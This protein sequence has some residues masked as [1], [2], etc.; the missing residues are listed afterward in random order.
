MSNLMAHPRFWER[1]AILV[2]TENQVGVDAYPN[3]TA[4]W[5]EARNVTFQPFDMETV[6]RNVGQP[7]FGNGAKLAN[8]KYSR[9]TFECALVGS[10]IAGSAPKLAPLLQASAFTEKVASGYSTTYNLISRDIRSV[11]IYVNIDG[12]LHKML[13]CRG[14]STITL[15]A[16]GVPLIKF[17]M[18]SIFTAP[19]SSALPTTINRRGWQVE[20]P[21]TSTT[22][23]GLSFSNS[24]TLDCGLV[25]NGTTLA[26][27]SLEITLGN[28]L[29]HVEAP[30]PQAEIAITDRQPTCSATVLAPP[31]SDFNPFAL[32]DAGAV[33]GLTFTQDNRPGYKVRID[34][35][36]RV[37]SIEYDQIDQML[38]YKLTLEPT[39]VAGNDELTLTYL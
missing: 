2:K 5:V 36:V 3:A 10:G 31:L 12:T 26:C 38:A 33:V 23:T 20:Q 22:A 7:Y 13:G 17:E 28:Q 4:N 34:S 25:F 21:V 1:K 6:E 37:I 14:T 18:E 39:P 35:K 8:G 29:S 9:L 15:D 24:T 32:A 30:G 19:T 16:K 27:S 11:T